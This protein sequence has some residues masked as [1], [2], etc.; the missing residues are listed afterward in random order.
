MRATSV[1]H[2]REIRMGIRHSACASSATGCAADDD[3]IARPECTAGNAD[4]LELEAVVHFRAPGLPFTGV[5][6]HLHD[7]ERMR[8]NELE[9]AHGGAECHGLSGVV[10]AGEGVVRV[11]GAGPDRRQHQGGRQPGERGFGYRH[12]SAHCLPVQ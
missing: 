8:M 1:I 2:T 10:D 6:P 3:P 12:E 4:V 11:D 5:V 7:Q 9:L